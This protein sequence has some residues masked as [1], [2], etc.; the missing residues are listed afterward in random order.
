ME[1]TLRSI[2]VLVCTFLALLPGANAAPV[3]GQGTWETTL[4]PRD[5]NSDGSVDAWFDSTLNITWLENANLADTDDLGGVIYITPYG[6]MNWN[7]ATAYVG[8]MNSGAYLGR[9]GWRLPR[10]ID[11][12]GDGCPGGP[13]DGGGDCSWNPDPATGEL[14]HMFRVTLGNIGILDP[15]TGGG[16][17]PSFLC[18]PGNTG[19]FSNFRPF[20][21]YWYGQENVADVSQAWQGSPLATQAPS[22]KGAQ[23]NIW[24]VLDGDI[25]VHVVEPLIVV[26]P[27]LP[28]G[29]EGSFYVE[30]L[31]A[32]GGV[33]PYT[34]AVS[35]G[36]LPAGLSLNP[37]TGEIS[38]IPTQKSTSQLQFVAMD[39]NQNTSEVILTLVIH[40]PV[41]C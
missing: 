31:T 34:W 2:L 7:T 29:I 3:S 8:K 40:S 28:V 35:A 5:L 24:P 13:T 23:Y 11:S 30:S 26:T 17:C 6:E 41:G 20:Y 9:T 15:I 38:G 22:S 12:G 37:A 16:T 10:H 4:H 32:T 27:T 25:G 21:P 18:S 19:P 39:A 33:L 36:A 14:M 1:A